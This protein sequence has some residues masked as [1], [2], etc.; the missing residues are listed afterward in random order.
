MKTVALR[1]SWCLGL[2]LLFS[3]AGYSGGV[4]GGEPP[5]GCTVVINESLPAVSGQLT[6]E[7]KTDDYGVV[8]FAGLCKG[9]VAYKK[10]CNPIL[11]DDVF[12]AIK[13]SDLYQ[14]ILPEFGPPECAD[15]CGGQNMIITRVT[16]FVNT[17]NKITAWITLKF[18]DWVCN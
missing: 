7:K 12:G 13:K 9:K 6:F 15:D 8:T 14:L 3:I 1:I 5:E 16:N 17:G 4:W 10:F 18:G 2:L 11:K